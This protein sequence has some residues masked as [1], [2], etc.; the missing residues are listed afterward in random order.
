VEIFEE[1]EKELELTFDLDLKSSLDM[2]SRWTGVPTDDLRSSLSVWDP[3]RVFKYLMNH[4]LFVIFSLARSREND[5]KPCWD[6]KRS[7][8]S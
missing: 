7:S 3:D 4:W 6:K 5:L 2:L 1:E 8:Q